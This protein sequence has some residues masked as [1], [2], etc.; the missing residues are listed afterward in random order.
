MKKIKQIIEM[1]KI[2][3]YH[4]QFIILF[5][6]IIGSAILDINAIPYIT[7]HMINVDIPQQNII[8]LSIFGIIYILFLIY[9]KI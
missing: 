7:R 2:S 3:G 1:Y 5:I 4:K 8:G 6:I 9:S